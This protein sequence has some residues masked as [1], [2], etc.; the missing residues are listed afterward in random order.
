MHPLI[1]TRRDQIA[2]LC[3][4]Y[5]VLRL[6]VFGS[7][8][9]ADFDPQRSDVDL[10]VEFAA[11]PVD[12]EFDRYFGLKQSLETLFGRSVDL[13]EMDSLRGTRLRKH[14]ENERVPIYGQAA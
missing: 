1:D 14:V 3:R 13:V 11:E 12:S 8:C 5:G 10:V 7:A 2:T 6:D 4:K 9:R